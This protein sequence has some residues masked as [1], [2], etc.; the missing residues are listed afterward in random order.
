MEKNDKKNRNPVKAGQVMCFIFD[1]CDDENY[2]YSNLV[3]SLEPRLAFTFFSA[4]NVNKKNSQSK[5]L[6]LAL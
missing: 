1:S 3:L 4:K 5:K 6:T 2:M